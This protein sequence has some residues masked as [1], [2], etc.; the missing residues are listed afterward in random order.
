MAGRKKYAAD[1]SKYQKLYAKILYGRGMTHGQIG[2]VLKVARE[3]ITAIKGKEGDWDE[4]RI[5]TYTPGALIDLVKDYIFKLGLRLNEGEHEEESQT[6][7]DLMRMTA[8]MKNLQEMIDTVSARDDMLSAQNFMDWVIANKYNDLTPLEA[9]QKYH[10][11]RAD[12][13]SI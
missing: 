1:L 10:D 7:Q 12:V 11:E 4:F 5:P 3:T 2:E 6:V 13:L 8:T 9:G